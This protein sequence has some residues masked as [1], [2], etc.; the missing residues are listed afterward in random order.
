MCSAFGRL[1]GA[2]PIVLFTALSIPGSGGSRTARLL[3][4]LSFVAIYSVERRL[5]RIT[6]GAHGRRARLLDR[7]RGSRRDGGGLTDRLC[8]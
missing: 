5:R 3:E 1:V 6:T 4:P 8:L 2:R 7:L